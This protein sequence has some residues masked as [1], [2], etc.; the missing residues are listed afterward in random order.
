MCF[1]L[2]EVCYMSNFQLMGTILFSLM[3]FIFF[4]PTTHWIFAFEYLLHTGFSPD[5]PGKEVGLLSYMK[6]FYLFCFFF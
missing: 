4:S 5:L 1:H 3:I 2:K 6:Y